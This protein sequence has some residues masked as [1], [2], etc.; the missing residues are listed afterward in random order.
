MIAVTEKLSWYV[1]RSSGIIAYLLVA[2]SILW[3]LTL[4]SRLV[5]RRGIPAWLLDLHKYLGTLSIVFTAV[6][7]LGLVADNYV[8]FGW[9]ELFV[10]MASPWRTGAVAWGIA[11]FYLLVAI[12]ITSWMMRR[13]PRKVWHAVHLLSFP[14]FITGT[15]HAFMAGAD[16]GSKVVQWTA[17]GVCDLVVLL[18]L[19]RALTF[20]P[21]RSKSAKSGAKVATV[22]T[23]PA[24]PPTPTPAARTVATAGAT[25]SGTAADKA[26]LAKAK[27][28]AAKAAIAA[29]ELS[30]FAP[31][32][33]E[34][35][36]L[37]L[38]AAP[39]PEPAPVAA[40]AAVSPT[41]PAP[42]NVFA[43]PPSGRPVELVSTR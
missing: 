23:A 33:D 30:V 21:R 6:H 11:A 10:P 18:S 29:A 17:L 38:P 28:A 35:R 42:A 5:R 1:S 22:A 34:R 43:A 4:S 15:V 8:H 3:G 39:E 25:A 13:L 14:L 24:T 9:R 20:T 37:V 19:F 40:P 7:L 16:A 31:H 36:G 12:Q 27:V 26:A 41:P 32:A 2:A